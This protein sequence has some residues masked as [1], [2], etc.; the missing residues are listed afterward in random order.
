MIGLISFLVSVFKWMLTCPH[1]LSHW[2]LWTEHTKLHEVLGTPRWMRWLLNRIYVN[3]VTSGI[4]VYNKAYNTAKHLTLWQHELHLLN[5]KRW[6]VIEQ[7][8]VKWKPGIFCHIYNWMKTPLNYSNLSFS[9]G[10]LIL[11]KSYRLPE[12]FWTINCNKFWTVNWHT[13]IDI[14]GYSET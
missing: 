7:Q 14:S 4:I 11:F 10:F 8:V 3:C 13:F 9:A 5:K 1:I 6:P 2:I 12:L